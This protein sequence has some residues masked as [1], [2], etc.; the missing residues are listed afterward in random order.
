MTKSRIYM[1]VCVSV[2]ETAYMTLMKK[3]QALC[4]VQY[5]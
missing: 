5:C 3:T 1:R 4:L 2:C